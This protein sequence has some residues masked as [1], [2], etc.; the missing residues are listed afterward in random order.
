MSLFSRDY[1]ELVFVQRGLTISEISKKHHFPRE[2]IIA[3]L[4]EY[5]LYNAASGDSLSE[6]ERTYDHSAIGAGGFAV[7]AGVPHD[8]IQI[9][10][11]GL[12]ETSGKDSSDF[13]VVGAA[14]ASRVA[15]E[16]ANDHLL[17]HA[18]SVV[19]GDTVDVTGAA[20]SDVLTFDGVKW[21]PAVPPGAVGGEANTV[22]NIGTGG[23]GLFDQKVGVD[24]QFRNIIAA[25]ANVTVTDNPVTN[26]IEIDVVAGG[27]GAN[28][29]GGDA[30]IAAG[31]NGVTVIHTLGAIPE[32]VGITPL[33]GFD[34]PW[35]VYDRAVGSFKVRY[36]GGVLQPVGTTGDFTW[37]AGVTPLSADR[38]VVTNPITIHHDDASPVDLVVPTPARC[39]ILKVAYF[40]TQNFNGAASTIDIGEDGDHSAF[41]ADALIPKLTT[42][43]PANS[44]VNEL[45]SSAIN[46]RCW[47]T[48]GAACTQGEG[49]I[50]ITYVNMS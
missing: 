12:P 42:T 5:G 31:D 23:C 25:S 10:V 4:I 29:D 30:A 34:A 33:V 22:S 36:K 7:I 39:E 28:V 32:F 26:N 3:D 20:A 48:P 11:S 45:Y 40:P 41:L 13:E 1:Y 15:H 27:A 2:A 8:F 37:T 18:D 16:A 6:H 44:V 21:V 14:A 43:P 17:L 49:I 50:V 46:I 19:D 9:G 35:E 38:I 47:I 24:L